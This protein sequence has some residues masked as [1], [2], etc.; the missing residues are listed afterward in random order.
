[1]LFT[2]SNYEVVTIFMATVKN[3]TTL[4]ECCLCFDT[5]LVVFKI[6]I[7]FALVDLAFVNG[8]CLYFKENTVS[9]CV[10]YDSFVHF[11]VCTDG[12]SSND[13]F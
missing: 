5:Q 2:F 7:P 9:C 8:L 6:S 12:K 10:C 3:H 13:P 1:M 11:F 4:D